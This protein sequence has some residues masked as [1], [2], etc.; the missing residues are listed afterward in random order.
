MLSQ[1]RES[2]NAFR[3]SKASQIRVEIS[4]EPT[5]LSLDISDNGAGIDPDILNG[6]RRADHCGLAG[7]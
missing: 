3:H 5:K 2:C 4:F 7:M 6:R 1:R